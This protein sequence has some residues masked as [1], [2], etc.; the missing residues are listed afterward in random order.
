[1][2]EIFDEG[3]VRAGVIV[4]EWFDAVDA[5]VAVKGT[6][7]HPIF[8]LNYFGDLSG[9]VER[10][11]IYFPVV[12]AIYPYFRVGVSEADCETVQILDTNSG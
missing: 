10:A 2:N 7:E 12:C 6:R 3:D 4:K 5:N 9:M 1:M 11:S 8:Y